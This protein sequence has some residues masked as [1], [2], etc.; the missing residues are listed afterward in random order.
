VVFSGSELS[1]ARVPYAPPHPVLD[2]TSFARCCKHVGKRVELVGVYCASRAATR[3]GSSPPACASNSV[4]AVTTRSACG[5]GLTPSTASATCPTIHGWANGSARSATRTGDEH[6]LRVPSSAGHLDVA[7]QGS[8]LQR[9]TAAEA[10][11]RLRG[12]SERHDRYRRSQWGSNRSGPDGPRSSDHG[13]SDSSCARRHAPLARQDRSVTGP[14]GGSAATE[15]HAA[16]PPAPA[17][18]PASVPPPPRIKE[19]TRAP[20]DGCEVALPPAAGAALTV[21]RHPRAR[22]RRCS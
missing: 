2:A 12:R 1:Q 7:R 21:A 20:A 14:L 10:R 18:Q 22:A 4:N 11:R 19:R 15:R 13:R 6:P 16:H 9:L 17:L 3:A 5:S 8:Q